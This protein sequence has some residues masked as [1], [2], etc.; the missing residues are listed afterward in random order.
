MSPRRRSVK[1]S[2]AIPSSLVSEV[3]H[4]REKTHIIGQVGRAAAIF[5]VDSIHIYPD[6]SDEDQLIRLVL[7]YMETPQYLRRRLF[8]KRPDLRYVGVLPPLRT[9]H[10]PLERRAAKLG[11]GELREGVVLAEGDG[12][13]L[14]DVG[15]E[16]PLRATGRAPSV[17]GR[18]T[19]KV[20]EVQPELRGRFVGRGEVA[21]YWGYDVHISGRS[22]G[23]LALSKEFDLTVATSRLGQP[24]QIVEEQLRARWAEARRVLVAFGS[25]RSGLGDILTREGLTL[26]EVFHFTVNTIPRQGSETVRTEEAVYATLAILNLLNS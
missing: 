12:E 2:M 3:P 4:L 25:P 15:V 7:S 23:E 13:F 11:G 16:R 18:A 20:T 17:G 10:H 9:P 6:G 8:S 1:L 5:R 24:F 19:V 21:L 14:V 26:E 22:L